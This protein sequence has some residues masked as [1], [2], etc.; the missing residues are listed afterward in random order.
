VRIHP[1]IPVLNFVLSLHTHRDVLNCVKV[2]CMSEARPESKNQSCITAPWVVRALPV[3]VHSLFWSQFFTQCDLVLSLS[4][5][6][7]LSFL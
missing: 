3:Q 4:I 5:Y 1:P 7:T 2:K 6:S